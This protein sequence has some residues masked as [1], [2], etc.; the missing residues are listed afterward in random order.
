MK[1][2]H[3]P[4]RNIY[5]VLDQVQTLP[6]MPAVIAEIM[7]AMKNEPLSISEFGGKISQDQALMA[8]VMRV[9]NSPFFG[10]SRQIGSISQAITVLG[11]NTLAGLVITAGMA[12]AFNRLPATFD[13]TG[14]WRHAIDTGVLAKVL[15][16]HAG[17]NPMLAFTAG[18]LHDIGILVLADNFHGEY[19]FVQELVGK[20]VELLDAEREVFGIDHAMIGARLAS[21]WNYPIE[22]GDSIGAHHKPVKSSVETTLQD[23]VYIANL[24]SSQV[25]YEDYPLH[26]VEET[27]TRL[28]LDSIVLAGLAKEA[29]RLSKAPASHYID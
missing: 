20:G 10:L 12:N 1:Q 8:R 7:E 26:L 24:L 15:A 14:F 23:V 11:F 16:R 4:S 18:L 5:A 28:G 19:G 3:A 6:S 27:W 9:A 17:L 2:T 13:Q 21:Q 22:I 25:S 29:E